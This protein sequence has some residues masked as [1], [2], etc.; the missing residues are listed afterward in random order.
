MRANNFYCL[1]IHKRIYIIYIKRE[2]Y[3]YIRTEHTQLVT[4][5]TVLIPVPLVVFELVAPALSAQ[6]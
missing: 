1:I 5:R 2:L 6:G 4:G 3:L